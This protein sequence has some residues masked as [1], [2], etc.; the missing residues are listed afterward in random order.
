MYAAD[1]TKDLKKFVESETA[2]LARRIDD[3]DDDE[4]FPGF[5]KSD[6]TDFTVGYD[7]ELYTVKVF[8][9]HTAQIVGSLEVNDGDKSLS[10]L[11][12]FASD[13][14]DAAKV[15]ELVDALVAWRAA[16]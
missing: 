16:K 6:H 4:L 2:V 10:G 8:N 3:K 7:G 15:N 1:Q 12:N 9:D 5:P 14:I 11:R 13:R